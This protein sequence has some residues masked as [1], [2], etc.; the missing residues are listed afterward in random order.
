MCR[1]DY[2]IGVPK[3]SAIKQGVNLAEN[4][5]FFANFESILSFHRL[6]TALEIMFASTVTPYL[7]KFSFAEST[8]V[9]PT[10]P[11]NAQ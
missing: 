5:S 2:G 10:V 3:L 1:F 7:S 11:L 8:F 4:Y 9:P 6:K